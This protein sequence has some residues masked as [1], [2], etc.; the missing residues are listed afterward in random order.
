MVAVHD[1]D[2]PVRLVGVFVA[3]ISKAA[4]A[5]AQLL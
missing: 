5:A 3:A 1:E 4:A 2:G